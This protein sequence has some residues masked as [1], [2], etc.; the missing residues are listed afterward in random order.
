[1]KKHGTFSPRDS[2]D[3]GE[4]R[5]DLSDTALL[6]DSSVDIREPRRPLKCRWHWVLCYTVIVIQF[7]V[8]VFL[9]CRPLHCKDPT[10]AIWSPA[11]DVVA[12]QTVTSEPYFFERSPYLGW[13]TPR[14][15]A[16]WEDLYDFGISAITRHEASQLLNETVPAPRAPDIYLTELQVFHDLHC[17]NFIRRW[18]WEDHYHG[19]VERDDNGV[20]NRNATNAFHVDH[21]ID[22][23][24]QSIMCTSDVT[25]RKYAPHEGDP[26]HA[27]AAIS[28]THI[29]RDFDAIKT[30]GKQRQTPWWA[31][32]FDEDPR[33]TQLTGQTGRRAGQDS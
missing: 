30:W 26:G 11:Q 20:I 18:V 22:N 33:E 32:G 12:Y 15:D 8:I 29:C 31:L 16:L 3:S 21:C 24:R 13:D 7:I 19:M 10:L 25:P 6:E 1:M 14:I 27:Y 4:S 5:D 23:L 28:A 9:A 17:L 2:A